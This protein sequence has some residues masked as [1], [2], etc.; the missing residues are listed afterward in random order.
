MF[1]FEGSSNDQA[2]Q[3]L[4][5][6]DWNLEMAVNLQMDIGHSSTPSEASPIVEIPPPRSPPRD[7]V[8]EVRAPIPPV[9]QVLVDDRFDVMN[10]GPRTRNASHPIFGV[11]TVMR[12]FRQEA[13]KSLSMTLT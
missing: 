7:P 3:A 4:E 11:R 2:K 8:D 9:R 10:S 5:A 1:C 13:R 12:D 6:C